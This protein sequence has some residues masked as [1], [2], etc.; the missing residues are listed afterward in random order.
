[1]NKLNEMDIADLTEQEVEQ[2][3]AYEKDMNKTHQGEEIYLLALKR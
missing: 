3:R 2:L 1:L